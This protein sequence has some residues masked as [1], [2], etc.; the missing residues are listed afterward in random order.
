[1]KKKKLT[2]NGFE[3]SSGNVFKDLGFADAEEMFAKTNLAIQINEL[4]KKKKLTQAQA[5]KLLD[6]DQPKISALNNEK[7]FGFSLARLFKFLTILGQDVTIQI[8]P[9][10]KSK[11]KAQVHVTLPKSK[12]KNL[13]SDHKKNQTETRIQAKKRTVK[14]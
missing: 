2:H 7:L 14:I 3:E 6:I 5:A 4:I 10:P 13:P 11:K 8:K 9:K 12:Q 1:M